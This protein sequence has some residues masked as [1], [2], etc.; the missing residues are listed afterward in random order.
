MRLF[1]GLVCVLLAI[2]VALPAFGGKKEGLP[3]V[4]KDDF[5]K[6]SNQWEMTDPNAWKFD[7]DEEKDVLSLFGASKYQPKVRSPHNIAW[8]KDLEISDFIM[9]VKVRQSGREYGHR[10]T[11]FFFGRQ[12]ASHFYYVHIAT[13]ADPHAHSV[14]LVN[15]EP[16]VSVCDD[17]TDGVQW[18]NNYHDIRIKRDSKSGTIEVYFD[19]MKTP[20][21]K[22]VDKTFTKGAIG[23]GSFDDTANFDSVKIWGR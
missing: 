3:L 17:R 19:D 11:C 16:R 14:F 10:D 5:K 22:T 1:S 6:S 23:I 21:M 7:K 2:L 18:K 13:V 9:D 15:G 4:F 20:I 12:D 8:I